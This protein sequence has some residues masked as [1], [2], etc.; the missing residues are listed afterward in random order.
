MTGSLNCSATP[1]VCAYKISTIVD[2][3]YFQKEQMMLFVNTNFYA[4]RLNSYGMRPM[5][6]AILETKLNYRKDSKILLLYKG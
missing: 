1:A 3:V 4:C 6:V 5:Q 2:N